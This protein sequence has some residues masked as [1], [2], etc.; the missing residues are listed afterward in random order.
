VLLWSGRRLEAG[1]TPAFTVRELSQG[2]EWLPAEAG[3]VAN[4]LVQRRLLSSSSNGYALT[5]SGKS[6][7]VELLRRHRLY[8][9]Y[10]GDLG[11]PTDH[12]HGPA[13]RVEHHLSPALTA[14][15]DEAAHHPE[16]D[17]Q[18]K[19]IPPPR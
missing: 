10:L 2:Q 4:R 6:A 19:P 15:V 3:A 8:E 11:Y 17:P 18:G 12:V 5:E 14:A 13:D 9:S 16:R 7:A 1:E